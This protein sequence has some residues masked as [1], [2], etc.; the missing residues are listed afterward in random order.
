MSEVDPVKSERSRKSR[1]KG[2]GFER[3]VAKAL[4]KWWGSGPLSFRRTPLSGGW[5]RTKAAGDLLVPDDFPWAIECKAT[6]LWDLAQLITGEGALV[7]Y[8]R[9]AATDAAYACP[10]RAPVLLL[11]NRSVGTLLVMRWCDVPADRLGPFPRQIR[12]QIDGERV[13]VYQF[14]ALLHDLDPEA[15]RLRKAAP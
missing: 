8:W 1:N 14:A 10:P 3:D 5:D 7:N 11:R 13:V 2:A 4:S 12:G 15:I 6:K 9:Q